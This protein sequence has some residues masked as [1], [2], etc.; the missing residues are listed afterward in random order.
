MCEAL[1]WHFGSE[2]L[3]FIATSS[4][5]VLCHSSCNAPSFAAFASLQRATYHFS[6]CSVGPFNGMVMWPTNLFFCTF[7]AG[8][9]S[10]YHVNVEK[11]LSTLISLCVVRG[12][13][14]VITPTSSLHTPHG[15]TN[16]QASHKHILHKHFYCNIYLNYHFHIVSTSWNPRWSALQIQP[17]SNKA[18]CFFVH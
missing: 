13:K 1:W 11:A 18:I 15:S 14:N 6:R 3:L 5:F 9:L 4:I 2:W 12:M 7:Q 17:C 16:R 10:H 8:Q